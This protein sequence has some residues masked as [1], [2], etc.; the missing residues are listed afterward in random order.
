MA[1][2]TIFELNGGVGD[3]LLVYDDKV[4]IT[5]KGILN[6][7]AMGIKGDKT[8]YYSDITSVQYKKPG[9]TAGYIQFSLPGGRESTGGVFAAT[10][11]ENTITLSNTAEVIS[12]AEKVVEYINDKLRDIKSGRSGATSPLSAADEVKK[13]KD[14]LDTGVISQEEFDAK[15]KQLLGL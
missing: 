4:V 1:S 6:F 9:F 13:F 8:L 10:N 12:T 5:H 3:T 15:K 7:F 14:L 2:T 11:D